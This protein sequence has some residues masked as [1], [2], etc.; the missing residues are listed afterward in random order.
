[1]K[2]PQ[3]DAIVAAFAR[4]GIDLSGWEE[5]FN[6][7]PIAD[8]PTVLESMK[9][10]AMWVRLDGVWCDAGVILEFERSC[11]NDDVEIHAIGAIRSYRARQS[12]SE[13]RIRVLT[14]MRRDII[15]SLAVYYG[16]TIPV[17]YK[18]ADGVISFDM[19][20]RF[21]EEGHGYVDIYAAILSDDI[22]LMTT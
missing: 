5:F 8:Q 13:I 18:N 21:V 20:L 7:S 12:R 1:M 22:Q 17:R 6:E 16:E 11:D 14:M 10:G 19:A 3:G 2:K 15:H 9:I 4:G